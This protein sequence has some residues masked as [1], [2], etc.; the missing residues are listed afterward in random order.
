LRLAGQTV[1]KLDREPLDR[2]DRCLSTDSPFTGSLS[3]CPTY[4]PTTP[5]RRCNHETSRSP[6]LAGGC[7]KAG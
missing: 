6:D 1:R 2:G 4:H 3:D 7:E 5:Y